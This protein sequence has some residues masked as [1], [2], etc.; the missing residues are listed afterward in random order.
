MRQGPSADISYDTGDDPGPGGREQADDS[1]HESRGVDPAETAQGMTR[2]EYADYMRQGPA[3]GAGDPGHADAGDYSDV[4][5]GPNGS[6]PEAEKIIFGGKELEVTHNAADGI[7]VE[8]L[9]GDPPARI[10]DVLSTPEEGE[11]SR[12][13][14]LREELNKDAE[15]IIDMG[16]QWTDLLRDAFGPPPP[17]H[18]MTQHRS[19]EMAAGRPEHGISAGHGV[20]AALTLAIAG[21]A[22]A[23]KLHEWWQGAREPRQDRREADHAG[24]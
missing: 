24:N 14:N 1:G 18:T 16:G 10:G 23:H 11:R 8:G 12:I 7:W 5:A 4:S 21:T 6:Q 17:T 9:T 19:P 3:A 15:D 22:A 13:E 2:T 20:E